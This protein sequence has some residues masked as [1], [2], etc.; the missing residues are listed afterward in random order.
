MNAHRPLPPELRE[1]VA[2]YDQRAEGWQ[3]L[4]VLDTL[5]ALDA[6]AF[7]VDLAGSPSPEDRALAVR[8]MR[9]LPDE[10]YLDVIEALLADADPRIAAAARDA[11]RRQ[12]RDDRWHALVETLTAVSDPTLA[13]A[14]DWLRDDSP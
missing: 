12:R 3:Q 14:A 9:L 6:P 10:R 4:A 5:A 11:M 13:A 1:L 2:A 7:A 8:V